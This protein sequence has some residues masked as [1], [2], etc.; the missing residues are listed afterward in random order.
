M[1]AQ[2]ICQNCGRPFTRKSANNSYELDCSDI[3]RINS[4]KRLKDLGLRGHEFHEAR[5]PRRIHHVKPVEP[6]GRRWLMTLWPS[7]R[8]R[9][10][11]A[12]G[13]LWIDPSDIGFPDAPLKRVWFHSPPERCQV[14]DAPVTVSTRYTRTRSGLVYCSPEHLASARPLPKPL[15]P[16]CPRPDKQGRYPT[17]EAAERAD[18]VRVRGIE[19]F[20]AYLCACTWWHLGNERDWG[21]TIGARAT[22]TRWDAS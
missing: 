6:T 11:R 5:K 8:R 22:I 20:H 13:L 3:C 12:A 1:S 7:Y 18:P 15:K 9:V 17:R 10:E 19:K 2:V 14:C 16:V 21:N 4:R